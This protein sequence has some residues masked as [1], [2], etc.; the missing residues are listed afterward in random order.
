M[1][2]AIIADIHSNLEALKAVLEDIHTEGVDQIIALG[3]IIGYG[4]DPKEV[5]RLVRQNNIISILGN[6][7]YALKN[8]SYFQHLN[9]TP[10]T[11]L[12]MNLA[13]LNRDER[14]Y[15]TN[16]PPVMTMHNAR[17]V[18]GCPPKSSTAYLMEPSPERL[19]KIILSFPE[20]I[21]FY[22]HTHLFG[23]YEYREG[24]V[25]NRDFSPGRHLF[26]PKSRYL[27]NPGSVGQPRDG[28]N[29]HSKYIV[30]DRHNLTLELK[31]IPYDLE[32]TAASLRAAGYPSF[33]AE[34]LFY[35][36]V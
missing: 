11:S 12:E 26:D 30:W 10:R 16:L 7:E 4:P 32:K 13:Q 23:L 17:F 29:N 31:S 33:N 14:D 28:L 21:A 9:P 8:K 6:H 34:R 36:F 35:W 3:D 24:V 2:I 5:T 15:L 18:H 25:K 20:Q 19:T 1:K 27:I 22:G